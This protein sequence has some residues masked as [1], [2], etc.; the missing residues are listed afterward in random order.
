MLHAPSPRLSAATREAIAQHTRLLE[1]RPDELRVAIESAELESWLRGGQ[2]SAL[3]ASLA[4]LSD[5]AS[6]LALVPVESL[7]AAD[8]DPSHGFASFV[9]S[10]ANAAVRAHAVAFAR[11]KGPRGESLAF[12]GGAGSGKS[13][14]LRAIAAELRQ[15]GLAAVLSYSA[16]QLSLDLITAIGGD[17]VAEF[18]ERLASAS[19]LVVD[20]LDALAGRDATQDELALALDTLRGRGVPIAVSLGRPVD[21][22]PGL[23]EALRAALGR[24]TALEMRAPEW[25]TRVA[26]V[27]SHARR[28]GVEPSSPVAA[29]LASRLR[30]NLGR[31]DA[32]LTRLMTRASAG[33][34]LFDLEVVKRLLNDSGEKPVATSPTDVLT[35]VSRQFN[36]RVRELRSASRSARVTVPRQVAMYLMRR[37][38]GLS[39][40]EIGR[41]FSRHHTTA[42]HA[43]RVVQEQLAENASLRAAV[44]LVEKELLRLSE[45]GG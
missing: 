24:F 9:A 4:T 36:V 23:S 20:D 11:S 21:R 2:L 13:H 42:L 27:V 40:P 38:C 31:L 14:L 26:I 45:G 17:G 37:Y 12:F 44:V 28:W 19:A 39:Y 25:E 33:N 7:A 16:E 43:D 5:G 15:S 29:F 18:R 10:P 34:A 32:T 3:D 30:S 6:S 35:A 1:Q 8:G 22:T 41:I